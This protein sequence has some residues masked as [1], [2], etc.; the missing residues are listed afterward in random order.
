[1][2][3]QIEKSAEKKEDSSKTYA[4][5]VVCQQ[6]SMFIPFKEDELNIVKFPEKGIFSYSFCDISTTYNVSM[7]TLLIFFSGK[8][9]RH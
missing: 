6:N 3:Q 2:E 9:F 4:L 8:C 7:V 1:M 5:R